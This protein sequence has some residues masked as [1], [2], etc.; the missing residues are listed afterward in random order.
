MKI[1][2]MT[3]DLDVLKSDLVAK[4][5][6]L[7]EANATLDKVISERS[8]LVA[9]LAH[10]QSEYDTLKQR[11]DNLLAEKNYWKKAAEEAHSNRLESDRKFKNYKR[12]TMAMEFTSDVSL[13]KQ[14][15]EVLFYFFIWSFLWH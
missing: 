2:D 3:G 5:L 8:E 7:A 15:Q 9:K 11:S 14:I 10:L 13:M 4:D 1:N 6:S 12:Q